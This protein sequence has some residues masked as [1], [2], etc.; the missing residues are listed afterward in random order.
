MFHEL[1]PFYDRFL[2]EKDY[3][4]EVR[5]LDELARKHGRSRGRT[6]LDVACGTGRHL[7]FLRATHDVTGLDRSPE[8]LRVAR[9]RLPRVA[10]VRGDMRT[11]RLPRRYDVI[12]CLFG[13][14]GNVPTE[15]GVQQTLLN[16]ANHLKPGGLLILEPWIDPEEYHV[17]FLRLM[18]YDDPSVKL[19]R[20]AF[21]DRRGNRSISRTHYLVG[22]RGRGMRHQE[23]VDVRRMVPYRTLAEMIRRAGL[24]TVMVR[25]GL[26]TGRSLFLGLRPR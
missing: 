5:R 7:E 6:W 24:R 8:M 17:G 3:R 18:K 13:A 22:E 21:S 19:V 4:G 12:S 23:E 16:F 20:L 15:Q 11:F 25:R 1:A 14:I 10:L 26:E 9:Q 2:E